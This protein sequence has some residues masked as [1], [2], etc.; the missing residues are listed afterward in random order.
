MVL[1]WLKTN[2]AKAREALQTEVGRFK[3]R[4]FM[5][6]VVSGCALVAA[7]DGDISSSEKQKMMKYI[8]NSDE[9]KVFKMEE[10]IAFF[11]KITEKFEFDAEIGK[12]E[13]LKHVGKLRDKPDAARVMVRVCIAIGASDGDFDDNEKAVVRT[14]ARELSLD[15]AD[16]DL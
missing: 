8:E 2:V 10:V 6:A 11:K 4:E 9:L 7:A 1:D 14:I 5:E 12:A 13:A 15:P 3:N 16:F